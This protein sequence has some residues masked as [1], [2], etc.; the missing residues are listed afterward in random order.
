MARK[1]GIRKVE[2]SQIL[3]VAKLRRN[4]GE[5]ELIVSEVQPPEI[6]KKKQGTVGEKVAR[7]PAGSK[8]QA[9]HMASVFVTL[10]PIPSATVLILLPTG[11]FRIRR[12]IDRSRF[13]KRK[14]LTKME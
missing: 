3:K 11:C 2:I 12:M 4:L 14:R 7:K 9:N 6:G 13:F 1:Y 8:V 5:I 10:D